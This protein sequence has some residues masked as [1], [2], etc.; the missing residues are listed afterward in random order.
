M[1]LVP[2]TKVF[3]LSNL[4]SSPMPCGMSAQHKV[5]F[6][7]ALETPVKDVFGAG[8]FFI[9]KEVPQAPVSGAGNEGEI[10][11][12]DAYKADFL[13]RFL[14]LFAPLDFFTS[15]HFNNRQ[16]MVNG[17]SHFVKAN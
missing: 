3:R 8:L 2:N 16:I 13:N 7:P 6:V 17:S 1:I 5:V 12:T 14:T 11:A 15:K 9:G 10:V 4:A